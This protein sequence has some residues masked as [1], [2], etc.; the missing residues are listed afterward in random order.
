MNTPQTFIKNLKLYDG[1][2]TYND[3]DIDEALTFQDQEYSYKMDILQIS[4]GTRYVLDVGW[5]PEFDP[6]GHFWVRGIQDYDWLKPITQQKCRSLAE[7]KKVIEE[8][9]ALLSSKNGS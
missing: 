3:F 6:K 4:F 9:A 5:Y 2:I 7:L 1:I 8:V